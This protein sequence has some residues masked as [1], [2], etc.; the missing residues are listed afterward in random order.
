MFP[1]PFNLAMLGCLKQWGCQQGNVGFIKPALARGCRQPPPKT[2][3]SLRF[4]APF[5]ASVGKHSCEAICNRHE[6]GWKC[7]P[8]FNGLPKKQQSVAGRK[9]RGEGTLIFAH[10]R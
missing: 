2:A 1:E 7:W 10:R 5:T 8:Q 9:M 6:T 4:R 3:D